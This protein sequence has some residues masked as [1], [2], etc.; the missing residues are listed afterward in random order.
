MDK[1]GK[2]NEK[3]YVATIIWVPKPS[4]AKKRPLDAAF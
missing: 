2:E 1:L 3:M 4:V